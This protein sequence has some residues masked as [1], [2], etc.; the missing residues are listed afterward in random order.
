MRSRWNWKRWPFALAVFLLSGANALAHEKWFV[1]ERSIPVGPPIFMRVDPVF[2]II[3]VTLG[4]LA[5]IGAAWLDRK[6]DGSRLMRWMDQRMSAARISPH[7]VLGA[8]LGASLMGAGLQ[9]TLFAPNLI[10][11]ATTWGVFLGLAEVGLGTLL[12]F[13]EPY[14][15]ELGVGLIL[16]FV[17]GLTVQPFWDQMEELL[18]VGIAVF[19][20]CNE[21]VRLPWR[22]WNTQERRRLGYQIF[23][24]LA[25]TN[26][27]ILAAVKWLRPELAETVIRQ[28]HL[29]FLAVAHVSDLQ[30]VFFAAVV[31]T[32]VAL[33][34]LFRVAFR[35]A[36]ITAFIFFTLSIFFL[37]FR[38]LL[39]HLPIKASLYLFF[40]YGHWHKDEKKP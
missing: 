31:E 20:I 39:G 11:P 1:D 18:I 36:V 40:V 8:L 21:T 15:P 4:A 9:Q 3:V 38:E 27:L 34:I 37:G 5:F 2:A 23:R 13:V 10:L 17:A 6:L 7:A 32:V 30:F 14:Y 28:H 26:F 35:P 24:V 22:R 16:L 33:C 29:N 25:G 12:L 19:F